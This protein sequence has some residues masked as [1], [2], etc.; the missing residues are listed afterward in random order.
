MRIRIPEILLGCFLTIAVFA[1]GMSLSSTG[2]LPNPAI[3]NNATTVEKSNGT[4]KTVSNPDSADER[5]ARYT[6]WLAI[7]T[8]GLVLVSFFQGYFLIRSDRTARISA[9]AAKLS[10]EAAVSAQ[11]PILIIN[12]VNLIAPG[13]PSIS[14]GMMLP[15]S[16]KPAIGFQNFGNGPAEISAGCLEW[17]VAAKPSDLPLPPNYKNVVPYTTNAVVLEKGSIPLDV[18][19]Q[20]ELSSGQLDALNTSQQFLWVFGYIA[21]K[22]VL[23]TSHETRFCM[24]WVRAREGSDGPFGFVWESATPEVY[25]RRTA[26]RS[27]P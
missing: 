11:R 18:S 13:I 4:S 20:I 17:I 6:L 25:T 10:A 27:G 8:G 2:F 3:E 23:S 1:M 24:K 22:S 9:E 7:L 26:P 16:L 15:Q 19:C 21:Y 12:S 14:H 5:V